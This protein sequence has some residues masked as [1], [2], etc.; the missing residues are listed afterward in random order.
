MHVSAQY[1]RNA[2]PCLWMVTSTQRI[3]QQKTFCSYFCLPC[4]RCMLVFDTC[5]MEASCV[6]DLTSSMVSGSP[7]QARLQSNPIGTLLRIVSGLTVTKVKV[8]V[9]KIDCCNTWVIRPALP[10]LQ[11]KKTGHNNEVV[12]LSSLCIGWNQRIGSVSIWC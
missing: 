7:L 5:G 4:S 3:R 12:S 6:K 8:A 1:D 9:T 11:L 10:A 2:I